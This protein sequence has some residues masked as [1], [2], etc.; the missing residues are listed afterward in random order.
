MK[1]K[2]LFCI[3]IFLIFINFLGCVKKE[4]NMTSTSKYIETKADTLNSEIITLDNILPN[5]V[6]TKLIYKGGFENS[7][8]ISI[9]EFIE[10]NKTQIRTTNSGIAVVKIY[11][12]RTDGIYII[13]SNEVSEEKKNYI[14]E[15]PNKEEVFVKG[16]ILQKT[17]WTDSNGNTYFITDLNSQVKTDAGIF[18]TIVIASEKNGNISRKFIAPNVGVVR[19]SFKTNNVEFLTEIKEISK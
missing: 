3:S 5:K 8:E 9:V 19:N 10:G 2:F 7:G 6:G 14:N 13:Y 12:K 17:S 1:K 11:E 16:P 18:N 4:Q 15:K